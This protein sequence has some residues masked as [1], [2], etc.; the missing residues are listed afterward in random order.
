MWP[1]KTWISLPIHAVWSESSLIAYAFYSLQAIQRA[2]DKNRCHTGHKGWSE[3]LLVTQ[4]LLWVLLCA[5]SYFLM[6]RLQW[7]CKRTV[8]A[9]IRIGKLEFEFC[10]LLYVPKTIF[11]Y[12]CS[13]L[14]ESCLTHWVQRGCRTRKANGTSDKRGWKRTYAICHIISNLLKQLLRGTTNHEKRLNCF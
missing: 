1:A 9:I 3:S 13:V 7:I 4:V 10:L 8:K 2:I 14:W 11:T 6:A 12:H 5:A